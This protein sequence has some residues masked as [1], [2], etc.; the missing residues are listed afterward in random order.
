MD[1]EKKVSIFIIGFVI[2]G[3]LISFLLPKEEQRNDEALIRVGAG[4]DMSGI[5]MEETVQS[6]SN[7]YTIKESLESSSFQDC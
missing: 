7:K 6:L 3:L 2:V 1:S 4:N 5:L